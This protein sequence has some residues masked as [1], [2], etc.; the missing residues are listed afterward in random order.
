MRYLFGIE[1]RIFHNLGEMLGNGT[2]RSYYMYFLMDYMLILLLDYLMTKQIT[3]FCLQRH[4]RKC[5]AGTKNHM[6]EWYERQ[7][8][9]RSH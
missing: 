8:Y 5:H 6:Q 3:S 4:M 7:R 9:A 1:W 2:E